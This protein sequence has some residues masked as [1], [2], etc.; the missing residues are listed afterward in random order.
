MK[1]MEKELAKPDEAN[2]PLKK[3]KSD[4]RDVTKYRW[5]IDADGKFNL[6]WDLAN[7]SIIVSFKSITTL[8]GS[9]S[10]FA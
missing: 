5:L 4:V 7:V 3:A 9:R 8:T 10:I 6:W 2:P 1:E